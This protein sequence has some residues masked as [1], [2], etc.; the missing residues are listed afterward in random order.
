ML[1]VAKGGGN[2]VVVIANS[3]VEELAL[4]GRGDLANIA[5]GRSG[6]AAIDAFFA[7]KGRKVRIST[8]PPGSVPDTVLR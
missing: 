1:L 6:K 5:K 4:I 3:A 8:Q 7:E 2:D